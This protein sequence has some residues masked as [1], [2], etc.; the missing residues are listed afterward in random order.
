MEKI[1]TI[2]SFL[3]LALGWFMLFES[4]IHDRGIGWFMLFDGFVAFTWLF[5][6]QRAMNNLTK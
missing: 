1:T 4:F 5:I 3:L 2:V 6:I